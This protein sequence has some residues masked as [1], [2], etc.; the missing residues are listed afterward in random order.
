LIGLNLNETAFILNDA[1]S[2]HDPPTSIHT[3]NNIEQNSLKCDA[4]TPS[5]SSCLSSSFSPTETL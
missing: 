2:R 3:E 5:F 1:K 4:I